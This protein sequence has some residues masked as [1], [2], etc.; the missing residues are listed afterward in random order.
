MAKA[1]FRVVDGKCQLP[2]AA[3]EVPKFAYKGDVIEVDEEF[4]AKFKGK[5]ERIMMPAAPNPA[6]QARAQ[7]VARVRADAEARA[8]AKQEAELKAKAAFAKTKADAEARAAAEA[9]KKA[10]AQ[11]AAQAGTPPA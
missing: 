4:A 5:F 2:R 6:E 10:T 8:K 11:T 9:R 3:G 1:K 7:Q